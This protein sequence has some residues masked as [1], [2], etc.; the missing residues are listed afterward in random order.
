MK[1]YYLGLDLGTNSIGWCVTDENYNIVKKHKLLLDANNKV[2]K[3]S[4]NHLWGARLFNEANSAAAR[5]QNRGNR[6]R[7]QRR[8]YRIK[9]LQE[10]FNSEMDKV[11]PNFFRRLNNSFLHNEDKDEDLRTD[12]LLFNSNN[13]NDKIYFKQYPTIYHLR[14]DIIEN[15]NKKF[16]IREIYLALAHMIKYRGNFLYES[17]ISSSNGGSEEI[18]TCFKNINN[19]LLNLNEN[20]DIEASYS[21]FDINSKIASAILNA[22]QSISKK[23]DLYDKLIST[24]SLT[25]LSKKESKND[26]RKSI[27]S[28]ICGKK[29]RIIYF[30][31]DNE[32]EDEDAK[33]PIDFSSDQFENEIKDKLPEILGD[34]LANLILE[35]QKIYNLKVLTNLLKGQSS[36]S[37][38]M[39]SIYKKHQSDLKNLKYIIKKCYPSKY[40]IFFSNKPENETTYASY[41]HKI[42]ALKNEDKS[43]SK[44]N[45][46]FLSTIKKLLNEVNTE[47]KND[48]E[49]IDNI[50]KDIDGENFLPRQNSSK[51]GV[52][53]YQLNLNEMREILKN[54]SKFYP[55]LAEEATDFNNPNKQCYKIESILK[56]KIPYF[57]GPLKT[58][59][60]KKQRDNH[61]VIKNEKYLKTTVTPWNFHE[62]INEKETANRFIENLKNYCTYIFN[63]QTLPKNSLIY[64]SFVLLNEMNKWKINGEFISLDIKRYLI[65]NVFLKIKKPT[66]KNIKEELRK[67]IKSDVDLSTSNKETLEDLDLHA[68]LASFIDFKNAFGEKFFIKDNEGVVIGVDHNLFNLAEKIINDITVFEDKTVLKERLK[69]YQLSDENIKFFSNLKYTGWA[70]L[71]KELL[72]GLKTEEIDISTGEVKE[73]SIMDLLKL[74]NQNFMEIY[75]SRNSN[76]TFSKQVDEINKKN[77][78][79]DFN[80]EEFIQK[81]YTSPAVKRTLRQTYKCIV[82]L[83]KILNIDSFDS[84]FIESTRQEDKIKK[85]TKSRMDTLK[86][87]IS[88]AKS[89]SNDIKIDE[90]QENLKNQNDETLR[91]K[92]IFLYFMQLGRSIYSGESIDFSDLVSNNSKYDI[93]HIIPQSKTKDDSFINTVLVEKERNNKKQDIYPIPNIRKDIISDKGR[94]W[95]E[96]LSKNKDLMPI[97]KYKRLIRQ[98]PLSDD[99]LSGFIERQLVNTSQ[100]NKAA[101]DLI[102]EIDPDANVIYSRA[103]LV[104]DFRHFFNIPKLRDL[105]DFHHAHDAY[106]NIVVGN[107]YNK[108]FTSPNGN[109]VKLNLQ[110]KSSFNFQVEKVF[111]KDEYGLINHKQYWVSKIYE[112]KIETNKKEGTIDKIRKYLNYNDVL[113]SKMLY[114]NVGAQGF[115]NKISIKTANENKAA[116]PLKFNSKLSGENYSKKYGGYSDLTTPFFTL[117]KSKSKNKILYSLESIPTIYRR[118]F[119][120]ISDEE[121]KKEKYLDFLKNKCNLSNPEIL[122]NKIL[123]GTIIEIGENEN[124]SKRIAITGKTGSNIIGINQNELYFSNTENKFIYLDTFKKI[125]K[126]LGTNIS[127]SANKPNLSIYEKET[128]DIKF[129]NQILTKLELSNLFTYIKTKIYSQPKF[130]LLF[131]N[132]FEKFNKV[133]VEKFSSLTTIGQVKLIFNMIKLLQCKSVQKTDFTYLDLSKNVGKLSCGKNFNYGTRLIQTSITGLYEK[134][135]FEVPKNNIG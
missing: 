130:N 123:Y 118:L 64:S 112:N 39:I 119:D 98:K 13:L 58:T 104:S 54:Q 74:T 126:L 67:K 31:K 80:V 56:Y 100:S 61:W 88:A 15:P 97:I 86:Q 129:S 125:C 50:I 65:T 116:F 45:A 115:F 36:I 120:S 29:V 40:K 128:S 77:L 110:N 60:N 135:I 10:I 81:S 34:E 124:E 26:L 106:L 73:Y 132:F 1:K 105:N 99:E 108:V 7:L 94:N 96:L 52:L 25:G 22:F 121:L 48:K 76:Y 95:I 101:C 37:K 57:V 9:L 49:L 78:G 47:D 70:R 11:D 53:P 3:Q 27:L 90:L 109:W 87:Y 131:K 16:D 28:I 6:R 14:N 71:S 32:I 134:V 42:K 69:E 63:E 127:N 103:S 17:N 62:V 4:G 30:I 19:I 8:K 20:D 89:L 83:K 2:L 23:D 84:Y 117:V 93:D 113:T 41:I 82:E 66:L 75:A 68:S 85:R 59:N 51:N 133:S 122:I 18:I 43:S 24:F 46:N 107:V 79:G 55:F 92:K 114:K 44:D 5:R 91:S 33:L 111:T 21:T 35:C 72:V 102:K 38:A 12:Y